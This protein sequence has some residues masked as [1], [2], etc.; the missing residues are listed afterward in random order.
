MNS[1]QVSFLLA[2]PWARLSCV[3]VHGDCSTPA[4][5]QPGRAGKHGSPHSREDACT[6]P[7]C[8]FKRTP[9]SQAAADGLD[10]AVPAWHGDQASKLH[11]RPTWNSQTPPDSSP[12]L[13][14]NSHHTKWHLACHHTHFAPSDTWKVLISASR[15]QTPWNRVLFWL[16]MPKTAL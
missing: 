9:D 4:T 12:H 6:P 7:G 16:L 3:A 14:P 5:S 1:R 10:P 11:V 2:F 15:G 8:T 13:F